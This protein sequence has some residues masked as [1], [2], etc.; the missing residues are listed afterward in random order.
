MTNILKT[1]THGSLLSKEFCIGLRAE[2]NHVNI[3]P[4]F[5]TVEGTGSIEYNSD[6]LDSS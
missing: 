3:I 1:N 4:Q 5:G 6:A 2:Q